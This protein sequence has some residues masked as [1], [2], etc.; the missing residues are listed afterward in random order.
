METKDRP[1]VYL[2]LEPRFHDVIKH[3]SKPLGDGFLLD[4][5]SMLGL[6]IIDRVSP[7]L[8]PPKCT[9]TD[10]TIKL[11][12][13][14]NDRNKYYYLNYYFTIKPFYREQIQNEVSLFLRM[15]AWQWD[16]EGR[17][18]GYGEKQIV[19]SF[20]ASWGMRQSEDA[21][22]MVKKIMYRERKH[23]REEIARNISGNLAKRESRDRILKK[24]TENPPELYLFEE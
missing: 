5:E 9:F 18:M 10:D 17:K 19:E 1:Y 8:F 12:L 11:Y 23:T 21:Y 4:G 16:I 14:I 2:R 7:D 24:K 3:E 20:L 6:F 15:K 22:E 13:P